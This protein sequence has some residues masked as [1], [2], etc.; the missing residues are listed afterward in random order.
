MQGVVNLLHGPQSNLRLTLK[1]ACKDVGCEYSE[2]LHPADLVTRIMEK[3]HKELPLK[4]AALNT[5]T[6]EE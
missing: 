2:T 6:D 5:L 4:M 3:L 1:C